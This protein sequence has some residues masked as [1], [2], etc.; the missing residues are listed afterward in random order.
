[1]EKRSVGWILSN[2][3]FIPINSLVLVDVVVSRLYL[4]CNYNKQYSMCGKTRGGQQG[5]Y[6][7]TKPV[8]VNENLGVEGTRGG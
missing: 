3:N 2:L 6:N 4:S 1:M 8:G 7:L 5:I